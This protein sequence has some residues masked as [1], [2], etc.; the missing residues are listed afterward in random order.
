MPKPALIAYAKQWAERII[1]SVP[2]APSFVYRINYKIGGSKR[3]PTPSG[4]SHFRKLLP[5]RILDA[6]LIAS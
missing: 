4:G 5:L 2:S 3:F 6:T 1:A